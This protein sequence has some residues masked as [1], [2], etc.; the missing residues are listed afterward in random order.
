MHHSP[1][2]ML[3]SYLIKGDRPSLLS[4]LFYEPRLQYRVNQSG[5]AKETVSSKISEN[6]EMLVCFICMGT[7]TLAYEKQGHATIASLVAKFRGCTH[8][9]SH[10]PPTKLACGGVP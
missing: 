9:K 7:Q 3:N 10:T 4:C 8:V 1:L 2:Q 6:I 5:S